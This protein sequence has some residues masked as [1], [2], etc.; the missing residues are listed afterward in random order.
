MCQV[1]DCDTAGDSST[2]SIIIILLNEL[3]KLLQV[4]LFVHVY[5]INFEISLSY[6]QVPYKQPYPGNYLSHAGVLW[7][8]KPINLVR[9]IIP[10]AEL[11][12][13]YV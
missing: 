5:L 7:H 1:C 6:K 4:F 8:S 3:S 9:F 2:V 11:I 12:I 10:L 13:L